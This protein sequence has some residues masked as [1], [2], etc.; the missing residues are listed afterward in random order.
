M[1]TSRRSCGGPGSLQ[2]TNCSGL[3]G[4]TDSAD[5]QQR[6]SEG[7]RG[8]FCPRTALEPDIPGRNRAVGQTAV[9]YGYPH[10]GRRPGCR[11]CSRAA[12]RWAGFDGTHARTRQD[13]GASQ[14]RVGAVDP[15]GLPVQLTATGLPK[16]ALFD[17][18]TG[19]F[20]W[21]P[22]SS[23][24]G[25]YTVTFT[26]TNSAGQTST[27]RVS[28]EAGR[29][30]P[31]L[32]SSAVSCSPNSIGVLNGMWLVNG[33]PIADPS[34]DSFELGGTEVRV[35]DQAAPMLF[36]SPTEVHFVCP[37]LSTGTN[38]S[39]VVETPAGTTGPLYSTMQ[40][41]S[42]RMLSLE[43]A[44]QALISFAGTSDLVTPRNSHVTGPAGTTRGS[45]CGLPGWAHRTKWP[46]AEWPSNSVT[47]MPKPNLSTRS[48]DTRVLKRSKYRSPRLRKRELPC[49]Y[50]FKYS[51]QRDNR[52][53]AIA[54]IRRLRSTA[55]SRFV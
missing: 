19:V 37:L 35:N 6:P 3:S 41:V 31:V 10:C 48:Q 8:G 25:Q 28:L 55:N 24:G 7:A 43:A 21:I 17:P 40:A 34:G 38:L 29:G 44:G 32:D 27:A 11:R 39:I 1:F 14:L 5:K 12:N 54:P 9:G 42:P 23:Q 36:A 22:G 47:C 2:S 46:L 45:R 13:R 16:G 52:S 51:V 20:S 33:E 18:A 4:R 53:P 50:A 26:A 49:R 15:G 30:V